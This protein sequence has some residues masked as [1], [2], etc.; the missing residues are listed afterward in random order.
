MPA[1]DPDQHCRVLRMTTVERQA[2]AGKLKEKLPEASVGVMCDA[3]EGSQLFRDHLAWAEKVGRIF[4]AQMDK[5]TR[6]QFP[7]SEV[8]AEAVHGLWKAELNF[9]QT[10][11]AF[12]AFAKAVI[13]RDLKNLRRGLIRSAK[14]QKR[15]RKIG[16]Q[17]GR[18]LCLRQELEWK[19]TQ[20]IEESCSP[21]SVDTGPQAEKL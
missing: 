20:R 1:A 5:A 13:N 3:A 9:N 21:K 10:R 19:N 2:S 14:R 8:V 15:E 18:E 17:K 12:K 11:G 6:A 7:Q 16:E 4:H